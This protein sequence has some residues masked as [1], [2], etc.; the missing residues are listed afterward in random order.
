MTTIKR[1]PIRRRGQMTKE[2][3]IPNKYQKVAYVDF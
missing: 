2:T 3:S 1:I